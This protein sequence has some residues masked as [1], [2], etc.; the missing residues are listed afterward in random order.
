MLHFTFMFDITGKIQFSDSTL[1]AEESGKHDAKWEQKK[2]PGRT[3]NGSIV[4]FL[5]WGSAI[6]KIVS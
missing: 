2:Y 3:A 5:Y 1:A 6:I 4:A